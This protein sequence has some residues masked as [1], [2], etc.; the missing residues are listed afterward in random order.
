MFY[1]A[2]Y[3]EIHCDFVNQE[4]LKQSGYA[5]YIAKKNIKKHSILL[6][7][8]ICGFVHITRSEMLRQIPRQ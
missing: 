8:K 3:E 5:L 2:F 6:K 1:N 7:E 4:N